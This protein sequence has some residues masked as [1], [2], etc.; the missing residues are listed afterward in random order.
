M[1]KCILGLLI[2]F[3]MSNYALSQDEF[4]TVYLDFENSLESIGGEFANLEFKTKSMASINNK[5]YVCGDILEKDKS[6]ILLLKINPEKMSIEGHWRYNIDQS[7]EA[8]FCKI[9]KNN[10]VI[11]VGT[12]L[13]NGQDKMVIL[14][15]NE[16]SKRLESTEIFENTKPIAAEFDNEG[17]LII[18][19]SKKVGE[20]ELLGLAKLC[21]I[22]YKSVAKEYVNKGDIQNN[23]S[24]NS[25]ERCFLIKDDGNYIFGFEFTE[26]RKRYYKV[27]MVNSDLTFRCSSAEIDCGLLKEDIPA[28]ARLAFD[29]DY[30]LFACGNTKK[31]NEQGEESDYNYF[32]FTNFGKCDKFEGHMMFSYKQSHRYYHWPN[33]DDLLVDVI[34][35]H[36]SNQLSA[37]VTTDSSLLDCQVTRFDISKLNDPQIGDKL[38]GL[39]LLLVSP[40]RENQNLSAHGELFFQDNNKIFVVST[41]DFKSSSDRN[42]C[43]KRIYG[44]EKSIGITK[45][46]LDYVG[47]AVA[48][49]M[50]SVEKYYFN[51]QFGE[52]VAPKMISKDDFIYLLSNFWPLNRDTKEDDEDL[53]PRLI[54]VSMN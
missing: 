26:E 12:T 5:L 46:D 37:L 44:V 7:S 8:Y 6:R 13:G 1:K 28:I 23:R 29:N 17:K 49:K 4:K 9:D 20:H 30:N 16:N 19:F 53:H 15:L 32:H 31:F 2:V 40:C 41:I 43:E 42:S 51:T 25:N 35:D 21:N 33:H 50:I 11:V 38:P 10:K 54:K 45:Y 36:T 34:I 22:N 14:I 27:V 3:C 24:A 48:P 52:A 18:L 47:Q 39:T